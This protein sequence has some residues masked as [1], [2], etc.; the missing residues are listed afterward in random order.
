VIDGAVFGEW[1][2]VSSLPHF[3]PDSA[4]LAFSASVGKAWHVVVDGVNGTALDRV[5]PPRFGASGRLA[6]LG[7]TAGSFSVIVDGISGPSFEEPT[8]VELNEPFLF[9][10]DGMHVATVGRL[11]GGW[12][13][14]VDDR[15]GPAYLGAGRIRFEGDGISFS[16]L[17][18]DGIHRASTSI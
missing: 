17:R 2:E 9:S 7:R 3:S 6:Y 13:P 10:P 5:S 8:Q 11:K 1:D 18:E 15:V 4:R 12:R 14:I 16:A